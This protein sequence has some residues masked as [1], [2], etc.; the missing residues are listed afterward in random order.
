MQGLFLLRNLRTTSDWRSTI[1]AHLV[2]SAP[3]ASGLWAHLV[4]S[5]PIASKPPGPTRPQT[6]LSRR[7]AEDQA[8][9]TVKLIGCPTASP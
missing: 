5:D 8:R 3:I 1:W 7:M 4:A 2:A 6:R 9:K